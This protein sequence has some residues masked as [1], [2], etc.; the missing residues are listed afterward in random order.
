MLKRVR[1]RL[2]PSMAVAL[3][4]LFVSMGGVG[5]SATG[6]NFILGQSND[7][8]NPTAL[9][10]PIDGPGLVVSNLST[11]ANSTALT[12]NTAA[13]HAPLK[14]Q[15]TTKVTNLNADLLDDVNAS[16]L[17]QKGVVQ[18]VN[19]SSGAVVN[20]KNPGD[21]NGVQ[22][23]TVSDVASG[24]YGEHIGDNGFGVAGR[25]GN[26]GN[27]IYGDNTGTGWAGYFEDKVH[28]GG[29]LDCNGCVGAS[30]IGGP[31]ANAA[32]AAFAA[33]ADRLDGIDSTG[34]MKGGG[35]AVGQAAAAPPN[36]AASLGPAPFGFLRLVYV[37]PPSIGGNG[38]FD[39]HNDS[40]STVNV[41]VESGEA[42]P[43][44]HAVI[45]GSG[46]AYAAAPFGESF[47]IQAQGPLGVLTIEAATVHRASRNDCYAQ[48]Q[49]I[50]TRQ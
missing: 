6:G 41:F 28:I 10:A 44:F 24:V 3:L 22:G 14:V 39:I 11:G 26:G 25:A 23:K 36:S 42:N 33:D 37:C 46:L 49:F 16:A 21:G 2:S 32:N 45:P 9:S 35:G 30:D 34:F 13:G 12:L 50:L 15:R 38:T 29:E 17:L 47:H 8:A 40:G 19:V 18:S 20:V 1:T 5:Y 31:V 48:G 7:A 43:E 27:A 4:A